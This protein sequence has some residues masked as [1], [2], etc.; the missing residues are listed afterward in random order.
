[1]LLERFHGPAKGVTAKSSPTDLVSDADRDAERMLVER[2]RKER[3]DDG[4]LSEEGA[5][6]NSTT[7]L[8]W[9]ID[10]LDGTVNFLFGIPVWAVSVAVQDDEGAVA[11]VVFNPNASETFAAARGA[12]ATLNEREIKVSDRRDLAT[13]LIG[14][15]FSY[16]PA[17]RTV[18]AE[19][20]RRALPV[21]RDIRRAGSAALDLSSVACG[22]LDGLYE[23]PLE[24]W[25][26]AAG[27]LILSEAGGRWTEMA[28]PVEGMSPGLIASGPALHDEL[29]K[30]VL[31]ETWT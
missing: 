9:V 26:K 20:V 13:A 21:V 25:D 16:D 27:L 22:R 18:Q 10:P 12:G 1:M 19:I 2:I 30:L 14:T 7:G 29:R 6:A 15:G 24:P 28:P 11:G 23:A 3:P 8:T 4:L 17:A 5:A 31:G